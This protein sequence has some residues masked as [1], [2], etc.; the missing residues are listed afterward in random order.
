MYALQIVSILVCAFTGLFCLFKPEAASRID[1]KIGGNFLKR[2]S[3]ATPFQERILF[4]IG[5][6]FLIFMAFLIWR[7]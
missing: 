5:G 2:G 4:R 7:V 3:V 6:L 1:G